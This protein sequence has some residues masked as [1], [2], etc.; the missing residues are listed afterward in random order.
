MRADDPALQVRSMSGIEG[1]KERVD[2][3]YT[4]TICDAFNAAWSKLIEAD[5]LLVGSIIAPSTSTI[6]ARRIIEI[7][8]RGM[9]D[10]AALRDDALEYL[11]ARSP[12]E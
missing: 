11:K 5:D 3:D 8:D 4:R 1:K 9:T 10:V 6:L 7:A 12:S 2:A